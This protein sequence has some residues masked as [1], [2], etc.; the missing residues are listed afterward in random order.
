MIEFYT[1]GAKRERVSQTQSVFRLLYKCWMELLSIHFM[2][3]SMTKMPVTGG[4]GVLGR[5]IVKHL[6]YMSYSERR[7]FTV[8]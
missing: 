7:L 1:Q 8:L 3:A 5:E 6:I 2:K 4:S